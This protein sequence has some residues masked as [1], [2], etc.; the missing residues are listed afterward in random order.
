MISIRRIEIVV[1]Y[2]RDSNQANASVACSVLNLT[3]SA[4]F[5]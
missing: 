2:A 1:T 4:G 5:P 3:K